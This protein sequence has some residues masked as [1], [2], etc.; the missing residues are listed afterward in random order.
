MA[1]QDGLASILEVLTRAELIRCSYPRKGAKV[2]Y[3]SFT[4]EKDVQEKTEGN[5]F[6]CFKEK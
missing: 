4:S 5:Y 2:N 1:R 6:A 3:V